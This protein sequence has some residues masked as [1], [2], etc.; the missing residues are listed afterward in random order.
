MGGKNSFHSGGGELSYLQVIIKV[1]DTLDDSKTRVT[2]F[3]NR[4]GLRTW[5]SF[6]LFYLHK[7]KFVINRIRIKTIL[8]FNDR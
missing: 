2:T 1:E 4:R 3:L 8:N 5:S 6:L 7:M